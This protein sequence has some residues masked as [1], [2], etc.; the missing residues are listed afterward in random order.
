MKKKQRIVI[1][2]TAV[3]LVIGLGV[4]YFLRNSPEDKCTSKDRE[5]NNCVPAGKCGP[6]EAIDAV[7]DCDVKNYDKKYNPYL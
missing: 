6:T 5:I 7:I 4:A 1:I 3:V 2:V